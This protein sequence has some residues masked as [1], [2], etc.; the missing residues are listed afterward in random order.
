[1]E[2]FLEEQTQDI[3][4]RKKATGTISG[5]KVS[6][7]VCEAPGPGHTSTGGS[8]VSPERAVVEGSAYYNLIPA[9]FRTFSN[10]SGAVVA[11]NGEF[12]A[13]SGTSLGDYGTMQSFRSV[14]AV[15]GSSIGVIFGA[16]FPS[17]DPLCWQG[18]GMFTIA[19][20]L[21]FGYNGSNFGVWHRYGGLAEVRTLTITGAAGGSE[22][23]SVELNGTAYSVPIT[24]GTVQ[25][26]AKEV[27][28]YLQANQ[29]AF[30]CFQVDD[31]VEISAK[32]DS[33]KTGAFTF[34]SSTATAAFATVTTGV[35]KT[36]DF[37]AQTSFNGSVPSNFD[38]SKGNNYKI[39]FSDGYGAANF[40]IYDKEE[41]RFTL[42]H[43][44]KWESEEKPILTNPSL[45][46]G[47]YAAALSS[48]SNVDV[49]ASH[50]KG[51]V[52]ADRDQTRNPRA[53]KNSQTVTTSLTN[54]LT[55]RNRRVYNGRVNQAEIEPS[56]ITVASE[57]S[58]NVQVEIRANATVTGDDNYQDIGNNLISQKNTTA[59]TV[60]SNGRLLS[61]FSVSPNS[62]ASINLKELG[63]IVP[64]TL[65]LIIAARVTSGAS[66]TVSAT[67]NWV[68]NI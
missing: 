45:H 44:V 15:Y 58:K 54:V 5:G 19:D 40:F 63:L 7:D 62:Q 55:I 23:A 31:A 26:N 34:S 53:E 25:H 24:S 59:V 52:H 56:V 11:E 50:F 36:N 66:A 46:V 22:T 2:L 47:F 68:E 3:N 20:E 57:S 1:M 17:N 60:G 48:I 16:R 33:P 10:G 4:G 42:A 12:K 43:S 35:A 65:R 8:V 6:L 18:A 9:N 39:I 64:P 14:S 32:S 41:R 51:F 61:A 49:Y 67:A 27:A 28:D 37:I 30:D 21:S 13:S 38:P 29:E